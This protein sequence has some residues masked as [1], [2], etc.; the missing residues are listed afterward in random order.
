[1]KL[2]SHFIKE[3]AEVERYKWFVHDFIASELQSLGL[4]KRVTSIPNF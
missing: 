4:L 3:E 2:K 1:M